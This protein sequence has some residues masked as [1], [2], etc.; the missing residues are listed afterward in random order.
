MDA[1]SL[2]RPPPESEFDEAIVGCNEK[3]YRR[4]NSLSRSTGAMQRLGE[5]PWVRPG[6]CSK[7]DGEKTE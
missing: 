3:T 4:A 5:M 1:M 2:S 7:P 6:D